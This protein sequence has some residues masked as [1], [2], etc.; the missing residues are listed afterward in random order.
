MEEGLPRIKF[1]RVCVFCGS[2][3]GNREIFSNAT[4]DLANELVIL[5]SLITHTLSS[6]SSSFLNWVFHVFTLGSLESNK[7][8]TFELKNAVLM[9]RTI[10]LVAF[11]VGITIYR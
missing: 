5:L 1:K 4:L 2:N 10:K 6:S 7:V 9:I 11:V 8:T 3:S